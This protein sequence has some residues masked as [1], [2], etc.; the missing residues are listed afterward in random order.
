[1]QFVTNPQVNPKP[2][3]LYFVC[4]QGN[5]SYS[6]VKTPNVLWCNILSIHYCSTCL[7]K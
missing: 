3:S 1:M 7:N 5:H 4:S 2:L 6:A